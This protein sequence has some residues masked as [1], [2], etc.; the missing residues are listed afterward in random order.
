[1]YKY[2]CFRCGYTTNRLQNFKRHLSRKN[3]CKPRLSDLS[4]SEVYNKNNIVFSSEKPKTS[5]KYLHFIHTLSK[6]YP[7]TN[8]IK[9]LR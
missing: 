1:M 5:T 8:V 4:I 3:I 6:T 2:N 9:R 7:Q